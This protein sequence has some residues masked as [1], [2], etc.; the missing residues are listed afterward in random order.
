M[1]PHE[2][3][4]TTSRSPSV[5][6]VLAAGVPSILRNAS[7]SLAGATFRQSSLPVS[8]LNT[9]VTSLSPSC[10]VRNNLFPAITGDDAPGGTSTFHF[11][12]VSGPSLVGGFWAAA[13]TPVPAG[14]RNCGH[15]AGS[16]AN[17]LEAKPTHASA[18]RMRTI[19]E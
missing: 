9:M 19:R 3:K 12:F 11:T 10:A 16:A 1:R 18:V 8:R 4:Y 2:P 6:G 7:I 13:A 5:T 14:P 17:A 15:G